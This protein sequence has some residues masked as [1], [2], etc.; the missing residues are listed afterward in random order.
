M[1]FPFHPTT[2]PQLNGKSSDASWKISTIFLFQ[3]TQFL[4][5]KIFFKYSSSHYFQHISFGSAKKKHIVMQKFSCCARQKKKLWEIKNNSL[6]IFRFQSF[7]FLGRK[8]LDTF[9]HTFFLLIL[10]ILGFSKKKKKMHF[11]NLLEKQKK[12]HFS[13]S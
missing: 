9:K 6:I 3:L 2:Q 7:L 13:V 1:F 10:F 4:F 11:R 8:K 5:F 12:N